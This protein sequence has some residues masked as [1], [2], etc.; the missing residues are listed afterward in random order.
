MMKVLLEHHGH[1]TAAGRELEARKPPRC[2]FYLAGLPTKKSEE[3]TFK[4]LPEVVNV[5]DT[6]KLS[7]VRYRVPRHPYT[8]VSITARP[9]AALGKGLP[10]FL[11]MRST[12]QRS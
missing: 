12:A 3:R 4:R 5:E 2:S 9:R 11:W 1:S 7:I 10:D 8:C 6:Q